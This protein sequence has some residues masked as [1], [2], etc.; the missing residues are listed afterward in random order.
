M[1][2]LFASD[3]FLPDEIFPDQ[4]FYPIFFTWQRIYRDFF[5]VII[6]IIIIFFFFFI[7][8]LKIYYYSVF[9]MCFIYRGWANQF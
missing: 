8:I 6:I 5:S 3:C 1:T 2:K 7:F 9:L 4:Y